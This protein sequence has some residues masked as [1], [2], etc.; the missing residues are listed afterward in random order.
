MKELKFS[1]KT[2]KVSNN[3]SPSSTRPPTKEQLLALSTDELVKMLLNPD[4]FRAANESRRRQIIRILQER[5]GNAFVQRL[6]GKKAA[7]AKP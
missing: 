2:I 4:L 3:M 1:K 5:E 6:L 7:P